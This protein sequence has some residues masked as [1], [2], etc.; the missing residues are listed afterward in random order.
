MDVETCWNKNTP[1]PLLTGKIVHMQFHKNMGVLI[2]QSFNASILLFYE[3]SSANCKLFVVS[4]MMT[5]KAEYL[6]RYMSNEPVA[7]KKKKEKVPVVGKS[8]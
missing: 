6:K 5:S 1:V 2:L 8:R 7:K 3:I 4:Y